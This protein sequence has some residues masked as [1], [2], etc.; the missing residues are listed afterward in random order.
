MGP[1]G[2]IGSAAGTPLAQTR[3][4]DVDRASQETESQ[5]RQA[6]ADLKAEQASGIGQT[7][8]DQQTSDRDADGRRIWEVGEEPSS[9]Q[10][11]EADEQAADSPRS[12]DPS[13]DRGQQ[14]DLSG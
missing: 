14:L 8:E 13:G 6:K 1:L 9:D 3:G 2:I 12:K 10:E 4:S 5:A 11:K 7:E